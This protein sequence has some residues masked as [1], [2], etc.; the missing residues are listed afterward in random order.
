MPARGGR[1]EYGG[2]LWQTDRSPRRVLCNSRTGRDPGEYWRTYRIPGFNSHDSACRASRPRHDRPGGVPGNRLQPDVRA[3]GKAGLERRRCRATA[4]TGGP[5]FRGCRLRSTRACRS[6]AAGRHVV[7]SGRGWGR[8]T[9]S[10]CEPESVSE[11]H[12][13]VLVTL[14]ASRA[15]PGFGRGW[16]LVR[17]RHRR[18]AGICGRKRASH[19]GNVSSPGSNR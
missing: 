10:C 16:S 13:S 14:V 1:S 4:R 2:G 9:V 15:S 6:G 11:R 17:G 3:S 12:G 8:K 7:G 5:G 19:C 18:S